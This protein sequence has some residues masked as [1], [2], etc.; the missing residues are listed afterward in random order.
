MQGSMSHGGTHGRRDQL[1]EAFAARTFGFSQR[2]RKSNFHLI[3]RL[4]GS[5]HATTCPLGRGGRPRRSLLIRVAGKVGHPDLTTRGGVVERALQRP[6][7]GDLLGTRRGRL[8]QE[9]PFSFS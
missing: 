1:S 9:L 8:L 6:L 3:R 5:I 2:G 7:W 4:S